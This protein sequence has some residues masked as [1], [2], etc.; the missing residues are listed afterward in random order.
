MS[1]NPLV[2]GLIPNIIIEH[3][4]NHREHN[5]NSIYKNMKIFVKIIL[6]KY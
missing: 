5:L 3:I 4:Q 6:I 1:N 2:R